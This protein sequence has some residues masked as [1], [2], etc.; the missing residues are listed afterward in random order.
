MASGAELDADQT[1]HVTG[2]VAQ[3]NRKLTRSSSG[4][5]PVVDVGSLSSSSDRSSF[6]P[7]SIHTNKNMETV[8]FCVKISFP[9]PLHVLCASA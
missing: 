8:W 7:T 5:S 4:S 9:S 2:H 1:E 3:S 6:R